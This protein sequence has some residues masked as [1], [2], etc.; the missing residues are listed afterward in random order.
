MSSAFSASTARK[1]VSFSHIVGLS[2]GGAVR[3]E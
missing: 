1:S 2:L 3:R